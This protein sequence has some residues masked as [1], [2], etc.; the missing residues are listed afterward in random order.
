MAM[1]MCMHMSC[2]M[3]GSGWRSVVSLRMFRRDMI[4]LC[5]MFGRLSMTSG[6]LGSRVLLLRGRYKRN[7]LRFDR[8][9][10]EWGMI[11]LRS[12]LGR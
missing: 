4:P 3:L 5:R 2:A 6:R 12:V 1:V 9:R 8:C 7:I 11:V 10:L